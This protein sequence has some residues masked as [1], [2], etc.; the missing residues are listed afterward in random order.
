MN[1]EQAFQTF[2][3]ESRDLLADMERILLALEAAPE[4]AELYNALFRCVHTIKGSGGMFGL[5]HVVGFTHVVES[6]LDR[7][8]NRELTLSRPLSHL[9]LRARDHISQLVELREPSEE[10]QLQA[11]D[12][13][14]LNA[15][16]AFL[17]PAEDTCAERNSWHISLRFD[18]Q[19]LKH[20]MD[21][22]GFINYLGK[23]GQICSITT[24]ADH[25]PC[26]PELDP[27]ACY[28][29]FEIDFDAADISQKDIEDVF[30]FAGE[31]CQ[32]RILPPRSNLAAYLQL[33]EELPEEP[34]RLGEILTA[35]GA[36]TA[37][38]LAQCLKAHTAEDP[39]AMRKP[40]GSALVDTGLPAPE[41]VNAVLDK[42]PV[43]RERKSSQ[44][45]RVSAEKLDQLINLVGEMV[46]ASATVSLNA[47]HGGDAAT[48]E[49]AAAMT[50]LVE[51]I[52]DRSLQLRMVPIGDTFNRF[53]RVVRDLAAE[54]GKDM[55]LS[56]NGADTELDKT[57]VEKLADPLTHLV[58]N[59]CDHGIEPAEQRHA[60]GKPANGTVKLNAFH[61]S[62]A[63][64]IEVSDDGG[65]LNRDRI[66]QKAIERGLVQAD[67]SLTDQEIFNLI[68][69]PGFSTADQVTNLSGRGVGMDVVRRN[70]EALR[71]RVDVDSAAGT[72]T[73]FRIRLPLTLAII[74]GFLSSVGDVT[75]VVPLE[76]VEECIEYD[77]HRQHDRERNILNLRGEVLPL[78]H[79]RDHFGV[80]CDKPRRQNVL[81]VNYAGV[82]AGLVV[83]A[84]LGEHQTVI[85]PLNNLFSRVPG[86]SGSTI[87][88]SGAVALI[89]DVPGLMQLALRQESRA[90]GS[91]GLP[92]NTPRAAPM[93]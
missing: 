90:M 37:D 4:D 13:E 17:T 50:L 33:F 93:H 80:T 67:A 19:I 72:G 92:V 41:Q 75:Y 70:I 46:I 71:G 36:L 65:G 91:L 23:L 59:A 15:L 76:S 28:L 45:L 84:L 6:L 64:V 58:R 39:A 73:E 79:L 30:E 51:E 25:L 35:S 57:V 14:L 12:R 49:S 81:V 18:S 34:Q 20:G 27:E 1:L 62:G 78:V 89:L 3:E 11:T 74:D 87:L 86:L 2:L 8:R 9:L 7:L 38:E 47:A 10:A 63:I 5:T 16:H 42:Q 29:G 40:I 48:R 56:I 54:L 26:L 52:R 53:Q 22:I 24:L 66:L 55:E 61:E 31:L 85:K 60:K 68:F 69:E 88:G 21:P 83:D 32:L 44:H 82:K 43:N 77:D